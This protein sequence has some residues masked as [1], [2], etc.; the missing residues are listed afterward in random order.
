MPFSRNCNVADCFIRGQGRS[1]I[2]YRQKHYS[3][4]YSFVQMGVH[5]PLISDVLLTL[6]AW[7]LNIT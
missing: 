1:E 3:T 7:N 4:N 2:G 6:E 5:S